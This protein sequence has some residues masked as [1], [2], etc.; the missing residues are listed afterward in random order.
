MKQIVFVSL[1]VVILTVFGCSTKETP[2]N[3]DHK[4]LISALDKTDSCV[5]AKVTDSLTILYPQFSKIDLVCGT[6]P[7]VDDKTVIL[8]AAA[9]FTGQCL[10]QF[11]HFNIAGNHVSG[12]TLFKGYPCKRNTGTFIAYDGTWEFHYCDNGQALK[13]ADENNGCGFCQEMLIYQSKKVKTTRPMSNKNIFRALCEKD[14]KLCLIESH[15]EVTFRQF[16]DALLSQNVTHAIYTD[17]GPGWNYM[18]YRTTPDAYPT[19]PHSQKGEF[20]TNWIT[21]YK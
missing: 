8:S 9:A 18:W 16:I 12:G 15:Y 13:K 21:F 7:S 14:K 1:L 5:Y 17:M 10:S 20:C 11:N 6:M 2:K 4:L 3:I 19:I